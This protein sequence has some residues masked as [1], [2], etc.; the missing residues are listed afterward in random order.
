MTVVCV[1]LGDP[2]PTISLYINGELIKQE[3]DRYLTQVVPNITR[4]MDVVS[5]FAD[6]GY[7]TPMQAARRIHIMRKYYLGHFLLKIL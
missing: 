4:R 1:A 6:N 5:C 3:K 2:T 7:G